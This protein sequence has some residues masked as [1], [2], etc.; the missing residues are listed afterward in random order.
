MSMS[1][2]TAL[3]MMIYSRRDACGCAEPLS[4]MTRPC[5]SFPPTQGRWYATGC[6]PIAGECATS[7]VILHGWSWG[8]HGELVADGA[9]IDHVDESSAHISML[10]TLLLLESRKQDYSGIAR[11]GMKLWN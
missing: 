9:A 2:F 11:L 4:P 8:E 3:A 10:E 1:V 6:C 7:S 5:P